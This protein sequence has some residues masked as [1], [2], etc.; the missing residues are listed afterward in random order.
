MIRRALACQVDLDVPW[1]GTPLPVLMRA[2]LDGRLLGNDQRRQHLIG[3]VSPD[4]ATRPVVR[5]GGPF[6]LKLH[7]AA[8]AAEGD[9][10][11]AVVDWLEGEAAGETLLAATD[12][13]R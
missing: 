11:L 6:A 7:P 10:V 9:E 13:P 3:A 2:A 5:R 4:R 12:P 8:R 1:Y